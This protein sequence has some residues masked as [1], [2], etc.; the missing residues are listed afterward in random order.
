MKTVETKRKL[1][2]SICIRKHRKTVEITKSRKKSGKKTKEL[3][4]NFRF[5][6][7]NGDCEVKNICVKIIEKG[8]LL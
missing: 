5:F 4:W 1:A 8:V 2:Y 6:P 3:L 7:I